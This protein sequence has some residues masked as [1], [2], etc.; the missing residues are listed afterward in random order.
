VKVVLKISGEKSETRT[1]PSA[2]D[3]DKLGGK[4]KTFSFYSQ[5]KR[6]KVA[7]HKFLRRP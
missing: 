2:G 4:K 3:A 7:D 1:E 5:D 6:E